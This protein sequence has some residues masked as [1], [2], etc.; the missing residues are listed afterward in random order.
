M[1]KSRLLPGQPCSSEDFFQQELT[2]S[3][4][5]QVL[6][7]SIFKLNIQEKLEPRTESTN[8]ILRSSLTPQDEG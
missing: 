5:F 7:V 1:G 2:L 6:Q 8:F 4:H 3:S